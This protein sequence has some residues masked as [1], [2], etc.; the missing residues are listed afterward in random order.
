MIAIDDDRPYDVVR[1]ALAEL[2]LPLIRLE[3]RRRGL[4]DLFTDEA[5][6]GGRPDARRADRDADG[7]PAMTG[8]TPSPVGSS[9]P[10]TASG[11][12]GSIYDLGYQGYEGPRLGRRSAATALFR[13]TLKG[14]FGIGRGG[15]AK[16][17]PLA[18][19]GLDDPAG[20]PRGRHRGA[21]RRRRAARL[22]GA[23]P[24]KYY[25][26]QPGS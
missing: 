7:W 4:E 20:H 2:G 25:D 17:A 13:N 8:A 14:C 23:S 10:T 24:V 9:A 16:I 12:G 6:A 15:R 5:A 11:P 21:R 1:D 19:A 22:D 18:L 3:Q 26:L